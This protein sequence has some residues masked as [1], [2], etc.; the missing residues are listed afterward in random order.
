MP[1]NVLEKMWARDKAGIRVPDRRRWLVG[2][3]VKQ[4]GNGGNPLSLGE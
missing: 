4:L 2:S 3:C 1:V